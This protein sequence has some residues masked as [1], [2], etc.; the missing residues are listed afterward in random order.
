MVQVESLEPRRTTG[1]AI[2]RRPDVRDDPAWMRLSIITVTVI[3]LGVF[4]VLPLMNVFAQAFA[5]GVAVYY[6]AL[7][8]TDTLSPRIVI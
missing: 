8:A 5:K 6:G 7:S 4:I 2:A 1:T 3:F